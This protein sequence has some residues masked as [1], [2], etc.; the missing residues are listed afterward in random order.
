MKDYNEE[1]PKPRN[2]CNVHVWDLVLQ[3][4]KDRDQQ[5]QKKYGYHLSP[6]NG[7][8]PLLDLYQEL[9]DALVYLRQELY[10]RYGE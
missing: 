3:D 8:D 9:L 2:T 5:G 6:H 10:E 1:E 7:R 4:M